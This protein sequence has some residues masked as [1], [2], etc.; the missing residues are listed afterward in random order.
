L[1]FSPDDL[2]DSPQICQQLKQQTSDENEYFIVLTASCGI[3]FLAPLRLGPGFIQAIIAFGSSSGSLCLAPDTPCAEL[4]VLFV[5]G[6]RYDEESYQFTKQHAS[7]KDHDFILYDL[8]HAALVTR[9]ITDEVIPESKVA[10]ITRSSDLWTFSENISRLT[11]ANAGTNQAGHFTCPADLSSCKSVLWIGKCEDLFF[12]TC[13]WNITGIDPVSKSEWQTASHKEL[14]KRLSLIERAKSAQTIGVVY[15]NTLPSVNQT[16]QRVEKLIKKKGKNM[17]QISI[18]QSADNT[19]FGNFA[20]VDVYALSSACTCGSLILN[21][22]THVP[23][24]SLTELEIALGVKRMF[25]G[26]E[27]NSDAG[28]EQEE[29]T[30]SPVT[31]SE[32]EIRDI[33]EFRDGMR[34]NWFGL[35]VAAGEH[36]IA[37][38]QEGATGIASGYV[39]EAK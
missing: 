4:P 28:D 5:F 9:L 7:V 27:W 16:L 1:Q 14:T 24:I 25:G 31:E 13:G 26:M 3:D 23:L 11:V 30:E 39:S 33:M 21:T 32:N 35:E 6:D 38:V 10:K 22:K 37:E 8:R 20:E 12:R 29:E 2:P 36:A 34:S 18:I 17:V 19:K 15:T